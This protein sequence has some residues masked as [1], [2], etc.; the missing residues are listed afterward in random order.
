MWH[1][2]P[3]HSAPTGIDTVWPALRWALVV[4]LRAA[5]KDRITGESMMHWKKGKAGDGC[6]WLWQIHFSYACS[7]VFGDTSTRASCPE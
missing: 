5:P 7:I 6:W 2:A 1:S 3:L 4:S